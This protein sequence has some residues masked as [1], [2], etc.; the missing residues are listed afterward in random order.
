MAG[1]P[2]LISALLER[3]ADCNDRISKHKKDGPL[4]ACCISG[5]GFVAVDC[6]RMD[7]FSRPALFLLIYIY[8][9]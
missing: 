3:K 4:Q 5:L 6:V 8:I 2:S 1:S 9:W 7:G